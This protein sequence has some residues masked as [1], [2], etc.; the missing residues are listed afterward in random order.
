[1][2]AYHQDGTLAWKKKE[3][4]YYKDNDGSLGVLEYFKDFDFLVK[5]IFFLRDCKEYSKRGAHAHVEL[6][7]IMICLSGGFDLKLDAIK[8]KTKIQIQA[9]NSY[10]FL[11][12]KVWREMT[13]FKSNTVILVLCDRE[14]QYDEVIN[15]YDF[16]TNL[17]EN[18]NE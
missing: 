8:A 15:D 18:I 17:I 14:Y 2:H 4:P 11:D 1:M 10:L 5:R 3:F 16:F 12:G 13:N 7:Q 6:K 9:D